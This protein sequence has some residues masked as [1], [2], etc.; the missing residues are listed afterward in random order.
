[1]NEY[2]LGKDIAE[3]KM[4]LAALEELIT[5]SQTPIEFDDL[6]VKG[7]IQAGIT[8][9][10]GTYECYIGST[11]YNIGDRS[12][13]GFYGHEICPG[14]TSLSDGSQWKLIPG[15]CNC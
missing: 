5:Q 2:E 9:C 12:R 13:I 15:T 11:R 6:I 4:R 10:E 3:I 14:T 1:M 7:G 8:F